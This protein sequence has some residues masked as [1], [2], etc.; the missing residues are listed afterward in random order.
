MSRIYF[1]SEHGD[2]ELMG[3]ERAWLDW[4]AGGPAR[5]YWDLEGRSLPFERAKEIMSMVKRSDRGNDLFELLAKAEAEESDN[6]RLWA[7]ARQAGVQ[8]PNTTYDAQRR[9]PD[10]LAL[11][12]RVQGLPLEVAGVELHSANVELNTALAVGSDAVAL[13][14]KIHGWCESHCWV[15]GPDRA[16][17]AGIIDAG[18]AMGMYR[19]GI[20][21]EPEKGAEKQWSSQGWESVTELLRSRDDGPVVL[22]YSVCD[23]FPN[24]HISDWEPPF[25]AGWKPDWADG[26]DRA[27]WDEKTAEEKDDYQR[28]TR[29]DEWYDLPFEQQW[30]PAMDAL[31]AEKPWARLSPDTLRVISFHLPVT[32]FDL[33]APDR[34]ERVRR[35]ADLIEPPVSDTTTQERS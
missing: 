17:M 4:I 26:D 22:S 18:L 35:A 28:E 15:E 5:A 10:S 19:R 6:K 34:D 16:W 24:R 3:S 9:L 29:H 30:Q 25:D 33:F 1:H 11:F 14:A 13:A 12:L 31:R 8:W 27:E 2:A 20:W 21:Y 32:I 23:R 7:E